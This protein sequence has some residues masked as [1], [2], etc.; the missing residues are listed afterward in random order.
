MVRPV[1]DAA[2]IRQR[3]ALVAYILQ[4]LGDGYT[5]AGHHADHHR[6]RRRPGRPRI[7]LRQPGTGCVTRHGSSPAPAVAPGTTVTWAGARA[8]ALSTGLPADL[9]AGSALP[10]APTGNPF[11]SPDSLLEY[12]LVDVQTQPPVLTSRIRLAL[13]QVQ[14]FIERVIRNLEPEVSAADIDA[15]R[16]EWMKR[17]RLWQANR[18]VFLWPENWLVPPELRDDQS[19]FFKQMM[20]TLLQGDITDDAAASAYLD[21]L[22]GLEEVAKL[23]PCGLYYQPGQPR[24]PTRPPTSWRGPRA[25]TASTTSGSSRT[26]AGR[27][28]PR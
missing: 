27:R 17:Y 21:Y 4:Q 25:R 22:T 15:S 28:G 12:F 19:P 9:P 8:I 1:N 13:S 14:L 24:T 11:D 7:E 18:E 6:G 2:R 23:E 26:A 20:S 5:H 10:V 16:W 3:D